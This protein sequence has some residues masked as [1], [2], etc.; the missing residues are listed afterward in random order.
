MNPRVCMTCT[1]FTVLHHVLC[2]Q[3]TRRSCVRYLSSSYLLRRE[4]FF[5]FMLLFLQFDKAMNSSI[6]ISP[7]IFIETH[8]GL[9]SFFLSRHNI[10]RGRSSRSSVDSGAP[11][12]YFG[13]DGFGIDAIDASSLYGSQYSFCSCSHCEDQQ[14]DKKNPLYGRTDLRLSFCS[15]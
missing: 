10:D 6:A 14:L 7:E 5:F 4:F 13:D 2:T 8:H 12:S 1:Q 11:R 3:S 15:R 9:L